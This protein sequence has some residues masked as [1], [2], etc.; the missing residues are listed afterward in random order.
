MELIR[1][2]HKDGDQWDGGTILDPNV[3]KVYRCTLSL[4]DAGAH[5][6]VRGYIGIS[7]LGRT[8]IWDRIN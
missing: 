8:Q 5:L 4:R 3:G 1:G 2:M 6:A 7:L